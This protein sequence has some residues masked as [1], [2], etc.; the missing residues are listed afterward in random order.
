MNQN[1][2]GVN[3]FLELRTVKSDE[4]WLSPNYRRD[5]CHLTQILYHPSTKTFN[6]YFFEYFDLIGELQPRP[7]WGKNFNLSTSH[8]ATIY[9]KFKDF[10]TVKTRL[11]PSD[12][13]TNSFLKGLFKK[14]RSL[15]EV[16]EVEE[17]GEE[18]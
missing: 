4:F 15:L 11:D 2:V 13:L 8:L 18:V 16:V 17:E 5:S 10:L 14:S 6:Q 9:P 3:S 12:I 7:H 1:K